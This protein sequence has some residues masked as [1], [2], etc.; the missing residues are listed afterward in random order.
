MGQTSTVGVG[1]TVIVKFFDGPA[2][3]LA[4]GVTVMVATTLVVP[5]LVAVKPAML[6]LPLAAKQ[7]LLEMSTGLGRLEVLHA[8]LVRGGAAG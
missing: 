2:Q 3:P 4:V 1:L 7:E 8:A 6:P 5:L